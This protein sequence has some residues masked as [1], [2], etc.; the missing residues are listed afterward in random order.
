MERKRQLHL[1]RTKMPPVE[2][3][4]KVERPATRCTRGKSTP[5]PDKAE[6]AHTERLSGILKLK[7][8]HIIEEIAESDLLA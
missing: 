1:G 8:P 2:I 5:A 4:P 6:G 3:Y 7:D